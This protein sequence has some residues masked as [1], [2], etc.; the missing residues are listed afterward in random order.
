MEHSLVG[1][2]PKWIP[3]LISLSIC[4]QL[5]DFSYHSFFPFL[6]ICMIYFLIILHQFICFTV[7]WLTYLHQKQHLN[8]TKAF[9]LLMKLCYSHLLSQIFHSSRP[10]LSC[11]KSPPLHWSA[12][13]LSTSS[14]T[15]SA[16]FPPQATPNSHPDSNTDCPSLACTSL[17][18]LTF[19]VL[20]FLNMLN[21][22]GP[23]GMK[24]HWKNRRGME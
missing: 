17:S 23:V 8:E 3:H 18:I 12:V 6:V 7:E 24:K 13:F 14:N 20:L 19:T 15:W 1:V 21:E 22:G 16:S 5:C 2:K 9:A 4:Q 11:G 10:G